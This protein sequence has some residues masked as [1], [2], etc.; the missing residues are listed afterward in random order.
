MV[1]RRG[2][3]AKQVERE[4]ERGCTRMVKRK[5]IQKRLCTQMVERDTKYE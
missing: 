2:K 1:E 5:K 3:D 4:R